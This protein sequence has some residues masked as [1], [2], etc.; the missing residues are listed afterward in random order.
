VA[1]KS[2]QV[3]EPEEEAIAALGN[4][5]WAEAKRHENLDKPYQNTPVNPTPSSIMLLDLFSSRA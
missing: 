5:D 1:N 2:W 3:T 4:R